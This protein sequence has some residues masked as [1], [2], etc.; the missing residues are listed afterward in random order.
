[1]AFSLRFVLLALVLIV[2]AIGLSFY[3][4]QNRAR[5]LDNNMY[6]LAPNCASYFPSIGAESAIDA[7]G[8]RSMMI[9]HRGAIVG[10]VPYG[11]VATI[12]SGIIDIAALRH[13]RLSSPWTNWPKDLRTELYQIVYENPIYPKNL[14]LDRPP[15]NHHDYAERV[16]RPQIELMRARGIWKDP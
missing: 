7:F 5:A 6:V 1:M 13:Q 16:T 14:Y 4:Q 8:G 15:Y 9:D 11:G 12:V 3:L 2:S 10:Q